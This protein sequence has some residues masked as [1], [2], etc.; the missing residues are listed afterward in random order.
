MAGLKEITPEEKLYYRIVELKKEFDLAFQ[1]FFASREKT[2]TKK[3]AVLID[4]RTGK[5]FA[6]GRNAKR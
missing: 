3:C 4:E 6:K 2:S 1:E 5:P